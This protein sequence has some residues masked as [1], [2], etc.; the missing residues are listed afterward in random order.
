MSGRLGCAA[1]YNAA[2]HW[3]GGGQRL[4][5]ALSGL[6]S[7]QWTRE[8][9]DTG[10]AQVT[11]MRNQMGPDCCLVLDAVHTWIHELTLYRDD[12]LCWQGPVTRVTEKPDR[13]EVFAQD[14]TGWFDKICNTQDLQ[15]EAGTWDAVR[16]FWNILRNE[17]YNQQLSVPVNWC[18]IDGYQVLEDCGSKPSFKKGLWVATM[19]EVIDE[20][21]QFGFDWTTIGR[22]LYISDRATDATPVV[23]R[24]TERAF[25]T[26]P[27]VVEDGA[28]AAT[29][30][31]ATSQTQTE[32]GLTYGMGRI[33]TPYGRLDM[34]THLSDTKA[35]T[36]DLKRAAQVLLGGRYPAPLSIKVPDGVGLHP[37]SPVQLSELVPGERFDIVTEGYCRQVAQGFRLDSVQ[38]AWESSGE[39]VNVSFIPLHDTIAVTA[40]AETAP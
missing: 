3:R 26:G 5:P 1:D 39:T 21:A 40:R 4:G 24:L 14:V 34:I 17:L 28:G 13:I 29:Y 9:N 25:L 30:A 37:D 16:M 27:E 8:R 18:G 12:V 32:P 11:V 20:L 10:T 15:Y 2:I 7:M 19:R 6:T 35:T 33:G 23:A 31:F 38:V 22:S 36:E